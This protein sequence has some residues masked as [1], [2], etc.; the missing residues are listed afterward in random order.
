MKTAMIMTT[1][2][3]KKKL[4][5]L[6]VVAFATIQREREKCARSKKRANKESESNGGENSNVNLNLLLCAK[7]N[8]AQQ[9]LATSFGILKSKMENFLTSSI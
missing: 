3:E 2:L 4:E 6:V 7:K 8:L 5:F 1:R 9:L